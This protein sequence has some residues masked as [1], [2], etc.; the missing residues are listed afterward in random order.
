MDGSR[1]P[2]LHNSI[3][4]GNRLRFGLNRLPLDKKSSIGWENS[5]T[6]CHWLQKTSTDWENSSTGWYN[7]STGC[8][9]LKIISTGWYHSSIGCHWLK[10]ISS[11]WKHSS[12]GWTNFSTG[13]HW[14][15]NNQPVEKIPQPICYI[16]QPIPTGQIIGQPIETISSLINRFPQLK[17]LLTRFRKFF[18]HSIDRRHWVI[19]HPKLFEMVGT[20][21]QRVHIASI[22]SSSIWGM[23]STGWHN[24]YAYE[25]WT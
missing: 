21:P 24:A 22:G 19:L 5:S 4:W 12:A 2:K 13:C 3:A 9:W 1:T 25:K 7:S 17:K 14:L 6:S 8:H 18:S 15:K 23:F 20:N 10:K 11:G 16:C